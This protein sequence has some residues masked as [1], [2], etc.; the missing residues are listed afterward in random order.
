MGVLA[1][2]DVSPHSAGMPWPLRKDPSKWSNELDAY[3]DMD[4]AKASELIQF[5]L[6]HKV[7]WSPL[8]QKQ[9]GIRETGPIV[10]RQDARALADP[11]LRSYYGERAFP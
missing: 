5:L 11:V 7:T 10:R 4:E 6:Q 9:W 8:F 1:G 2:A 3:A